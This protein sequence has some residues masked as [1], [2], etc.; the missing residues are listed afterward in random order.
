MFMD[1]KVKVLSPTAIQKLQLTL[2]S[3]REQSLF[4]TV[5]YGDAII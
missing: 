1:H 2:K 4:M 5:I 3:I